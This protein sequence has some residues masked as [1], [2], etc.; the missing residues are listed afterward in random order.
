MASFNDLNQANSSFQTFNN[1]LNSLQQ[2]ISNGTLST[3][4]A[5][6]QLSAL[7]KSFNDLNQSSQEF[8]NNNQNLQNNFQTLNDSVAECNTQLQ[9]MQNLLNSN[10]SQKE[11]SILQIVNSINTMKD[12]INGVS[13]AFQQLDNKSL[14]LSNVKN[15]ITNVK[16]LFNEFISSAKLDDIKPE[17]Y[18]QIIT[19]MQNVSNQMST[20][21][22]NMTKMSIIAGPEEQQKVKE[23]ITAISDII[24]LLPDMV[25]TKTSNMFS[26][27]IKNATQNIQDSDFQQFF[28]KI[29]QLRNINYKPS[30]GSTMFDVNAQ[31]QQNSD[32]KSQQLNESQQKM[33]NYYSLN[34]NAGKIDSITSSSIPNLE[35]IE[36]AI[37]NLILKYNSNGFTNNQ[38]Q[39]LNNAGL[40]QDNLKSA[41]HDIQYMEN[42]S[43]TYQNNIGDLQGNIK[44]YNKSVNE[45]NPDQELS[46]TIH[47]QIRE[48]INM[49]TQIS[50]FQSNLG[51][52]LNL[53]DLDKLPND[54]KDIIESLSKSMK[55]NIDV[56]DLLTKES[57]LFGTALGDKLKE[58]FDKAKESLDETSEKFSSFSDEMNN[59]SGYGG[60]ILSGIGGK[61][62]DVVSG[63]QG[64]SGTL[65]RLG[66]GVGIP[67]SLAGLTNFAKGSVDYYKEF[68]TMDMNTSRS[69]I[70]TGGNIDDNV[71]NQNRSIGMQQYADTHGMVNYDDYSKM[72][73]SVLQSTGG[74]VNG[75]TYG[76]K[77][78]S[79]MSN[80]TK[81]GQDM[82]LAYGIDKGQMSGYISTYYKDLNMDADDTS[83][84]LLKL[85]NVATQSNQ[86]VNDFLQTVTNL[87]K[88]FKDVGLNA[89]DAQNLMTQFT[90]QGM[91]LNT[92]SGLT[93]SVG[94]A[95]NSVGTGDAN[96]MFWGMMSGQTTDPWSAGW[97]SV[98]RYNAKGDVKPGADDYLANSLDA[99]LGMMKMVYGGNYDMQ[100]LG[101][102]N[103][104]TSMG[105][106]QKN[107]DMLT[108]QYLD[109]GGNTSTFKNMLKSA[110]DQMN[111]TTGNQSTSSMQSGLENKIKSASDKMDEITKALNDSKSV[112]QQ[113]A[114]VNKQLLDTYGKT[115][116]GLINTLGKDI[117]GLDGSIANLFKS[118]SLLGGLL[119][120][121]INHPVWGTIATIATLLGGKAAIKKA[122]SK[123]A[124]TVAGKFGSSAAKSA[125]TE[126]AEKTAE[127]AGTKV[128][129]SVGKSALS[130]FAKVLPF[131]I[132]SVAGGIIN[133]VQAY[134][135]GDSASEIALK[136][137]AG[138]G[139]G[140]ISAIPGIGTVAGIGLGIGADFAANAGIDKL[141]GTSGSSSSKSSSNGTFT[142]QNLESNTKLMSSQ[143]EL[144][145]K[146]VQDFKDKT[147]LALD[148]SNT[149][150]E[151][152]Y[153]M[154]TDK[155]NKM[156]DS[157]KDQFSEVKIIASMTNQGFTT[158]S[159]YLAAILQQVT[160]IY[161][162]MGNGDS[163][164]N[165]SD[166]S[167]QYVNGDG[168]KTMAGNG[169]SPLHD[170]GDKQI[171]QWDSQIVNAAK[172]Y[173][174]DPN[175]L[176]AIMKQESSGKPNEVSNQGAV[177]LMQLL[178]STAAEL[179]YSGDLTDPQTSLYAG[180]AYISKMLKAK[181]GDLQKAISAYNAGPAGNFNNS[182]T[183]NYRKKVSSNYATLLKNNNISSV[184]SSSSSSS[185]S[186]GSSGSSVN[187]FL[188]NLDTKIGDGIDKVETTIYDN[189]VGKIKK[190]FGYA[191]GTDSATSGYK[192]V[193]ENGPELVNFSGGEQVLDNNT[194]SSIT[195]ALSSGSYGIPANVIKFGEQELSNNNNYLNTNGLTVNN[196][197][198][199]S[200]MSSMV[201]V[202]GLSRGILNSYLSSNTKDR[203]KN[204]VPTS[205]NIFTLN[206]N[207]SNT[208]KNNTP[209]PS[210]NIGINV[211]NN[212]N[213]QLYNKMASEIKGVVESVV[214]NNYMDMNNV[215]MSSYLRNNQ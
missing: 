43:D 129:S 144:T 180:A 34:K 179:G 142:A 94:K 91:S 202:Q 19:M 119:Q 146:Q 134:K 5:V 193:G 141:Y 96:S 66:M 108:N 76:E 187:S 196:L 14:D 44:K 185:S 105:I 152:S 170:I 211:N 16:Q 174:I 100:H 23:G 80:L 63:I 205:S 214:K 42:M 184:S 41:L 107:A 87:S 159:K 59:Q 125:T 55:D 98:D 192:L 37:N 49:S 27:A 112:Q 102:Y 212:E 45:G 71:L 13:D 104:F 176:K 3:D 18:N 164:S 31:N 136:S 127:K 52:S 10:D 203:Y 53:D 68:G 60:N 73:Q 124:S 4:D 133:G 121:L 57:D 183:A 199:S 167:N 172:K 46:S 106:D 158:V 206:N 153:T 78:N 32:F 9:N 140:L 97:K 103:T 177:G 157:A 2:G 145:N 39:S 70:G 111:K 173:N 95:L 139:T 101:I 115:A 194:T 168:I 114:N 88:S 20:S 117:V 36:N 77:N 30:N 126:A 89:G 64:I 47:N 209:S 150:N 24:T 198:E 7:Q 92:A 207:T 163:S 48:L 86:P 132:G 113:L 123:I 90:M 65:N 54:I 15:E 6:Q 151:N 93:S 181:N 8:Q 204:I 160:N 110:Q 169:N 189:T 74:N 79:D 58:N 120:E 128:A 165:S 210:F 22:N 143:Q 29:E 38:Q 175:L 35:N 191:G 109:N 188:K 201:D 148:T 67:T 116:Q 215:A 50:Q 190:I 40:S 208:N 84:T 138:V 11:Q 195:N 131:G 33:F 83:K 156:I 213:S 12:T 149:F 25:K 197:G 1:Q 166:S 82:S 182:E 62:G 200:I 56:M 178:P 61:I 171:D 17:N 137:A 75:Y 130:R 147:N 122:G 118:N 162:S 26:E 85:A 81:T 28:D 161:K 135:E 154:Y 99:Q 186:S 72:Y 155:Y 51:S 69:M 21:L